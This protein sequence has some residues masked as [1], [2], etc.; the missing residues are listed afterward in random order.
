M[1]TECVLTFLPYDLATLG[2]LVKYIPLP[3]AA[4]K[5]VLPPTDPNFFLNKPPPVP[6]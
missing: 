5:P 3:N 1:L 4:S 2:S 6:R